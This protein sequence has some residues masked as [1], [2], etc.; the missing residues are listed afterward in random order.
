M[1]GL[2]V[3]HKRDLRNNIGH[4]NK[5]SEEK[6]INYISKY[7]KY[8]RSIIHKINGSDYD[9][10]ISSQF[11]SSF[12]MSIF[13][14]NSS[15]LISTNAY[16]K[17]NDINTTSIKSSKDWW[18]DIFMDNKLSL[19]TDSNI[20]LNSDNAGGS[21]IL[22]EV[23]SF[24]ILQRLFDCKL[25][26]TEMQIDYYPYGSKKT[27]YTV[28]IDHPIKRTIAVSVTRVMKYT[29]EYDE[30]DKHLTF[31]Y[32]KHILEKKLSCIYWSN[33]NVTDKYKWDKQILHVFVRSR[34]AQ[35]LLRK[36]YKSIPDARKTGVVIICTICSNMKYMFL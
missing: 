25:K 19:S 22:S 30:S 32:T 14:V 10:S 13:N 1:N 36:A 2:A 18:K 5:V 26:H 24:E 12:D 20:I 11:A 7:S 34:K 15:T 9:L 33:R 27:D 21:S 35:K 8:P 23:L 29:H 31:E 16:G 28:I 3:I 17:I 4:R 6:K